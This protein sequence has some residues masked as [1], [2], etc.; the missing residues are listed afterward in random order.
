MDPM[1][2]A[3]L[4]APEGSPLVNQ[5]APVVSPSIPSTD[6][7][8]DQNPSA[9][10]ASVRPEWLPEKFW[11]ATKNEA[12]ADD[13][14]SHLSKL[15]EIGAADEARR[16][17]LPAKPEEYKA[18]LP[19]DLGL[20]PE[21]AINEQDSRLLEL[22]KIAHE[23]GLSQ[24][25][26]DRL[27]R[28]DAM[29]T[30]SEVTRDAD[31]LKQGLDVRNKVL[32]ENGAARVEELSKWIE[33]RVPDAK[34]NEHVKSNV[35]RPEMVQ[36]LEGVRKELIGQGGQPFVQSGREA[37]RADGRPENFTSLRPHDQILINRQLAAGG[38]K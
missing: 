18:T 26:F 14:K 8:T 10:N 11:D 24:K 35:I 13:F 31:V 3:P 5:V 27:V 9:Q 19:A 16:V 22:R 2:N 4:I 36:F 21:F 25:T 6:T 20:P 30:A 34:I 32:G 12:K 7:G 23:D 15:E 29:R 38:R 28:L 37:P 17:G 1:T 33:A